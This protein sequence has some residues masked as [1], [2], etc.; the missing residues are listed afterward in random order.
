M[1][2]RL[3]A[4]L[5]LVVALACTGPVLAQDYTP[6]QIYEM[7]N[8]GHVDQAL[9]AM[10]EV[11]KNHPDKAEAHYVDAELQARVGNFPRAR[12][13]L[14]TALRLNPS[15][16]L[17]K[18]E[19]LAALQRQLARGEVSRGST[20]SYPGPMVQRVEHRSGSFWPFALLIF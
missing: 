1:F 9:Q 2:K 6:H 15:G 8:S 18:P 20:S 12:E 16:S 17:A 10:N 5:V 3:A 19:A 13:E 4:P 7:A 14:A 11:L